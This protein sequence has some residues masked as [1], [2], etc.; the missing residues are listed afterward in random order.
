[1]ETIRTTQSVDYTNPEHWIKVIKS[2]KR[3]IIRKLNDRRF[4]FK[5]QMNLEYH[6]SI[7]DEIRLYFEIK[8]FS[9]Y[10]HTSWNGVDFPK[11]RFMRCLDLLPS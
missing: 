6:F 1:M 11:E 10:C 8:K 9:V 3:K 7:K 5:R 4:Y 2:N